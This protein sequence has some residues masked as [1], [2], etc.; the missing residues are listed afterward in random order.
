M[1]VQISGDPWNPVAGCTKISPGCK[2]CYAESFFARLQCM[3]NK[4]YTSG[5]ALTLH[6]DLID[7]PRA[8]KKL[9]TFFVNSMNDLFHKDIPFD[10]IAAVFKTMVNA[11]DF[12]VRI[13]FS[14]V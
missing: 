3:D 7:L 14:L 8:K 4:R 6:S 10:F 12:I 9:Q 5:F 13:P 1:S 2:G 11:F